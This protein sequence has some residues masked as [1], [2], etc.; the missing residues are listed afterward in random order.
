MKMSGGT[1]ICIFKKS[2]LIVLAIGIAGGTLLYTKLACRE[3]LQK[4]D[5]QI[6]ELYAK[7]LEISCKH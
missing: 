1:D 6:V 4:K 2:M 5:K 3:K 7:G